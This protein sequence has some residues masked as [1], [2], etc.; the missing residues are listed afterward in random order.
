MMFKVGQRV[1]FIEM[2]CIFP[3]DSIDKGE[4]GVITVINDELISIK[5]DKHHDGLEY[6][7]NETHI[8]SDDERKPTDYIKVIK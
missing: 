2:W 6:W 1:E 7:Q 8:Y 4:T 3:E 5:M